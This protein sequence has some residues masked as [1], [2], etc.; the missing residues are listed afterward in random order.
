MANANPARLGQIN[1]AGD[2][3]ALFLPS[4]GGVIVPVSL[5]SLDSRIV[6]LGDSITAAR[7]FA[8][9]TDWALYKARGRYYTKL[10]GS[11]G[12][13]PT[14]WN[15]GVVGNTSAQGIARLSNVS[16]ETPKVVVILFGCNDI[17]NSGGTY[18]SI[19]ANL[20]TIIDAVKA[21]GA[22]CVLCTII[23]GS[24]S[25]YMAAMETIRLNVNDWIRAQTDVTV[26]DTS[27]LI[28]D[29]STQ[30]MVDG[31]HP[32]GT[33]AQLMGYATG[34]VGDKIAS[35]ISASDILYTTGSIPAE[36][37]YTNPLFTGGT[38]SAT[39]WTF[40]SNSNGLTKAASKTTLD[41]YEAQRYVASGTASANSADNF[42][43]NVTVTGGV[44]GDSVEAWVEVLVTK[45]VGISGISISAGTNATAN[46]M[47]S[48]SA[49]DS[50]TRS[51]PF[52]GVM[53]AP[54]SVLTSN[55]QVMNSRISI[56]PANG[57]VVDADITFLRAGYRKV[58]A[59][60]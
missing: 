55:G 17:T 49:Q 37:L 14:G 5:L 28:T 35:L 60:I 11:N 34:G 19:T 42:N 4:H 24:A 41:G 12:T 56:L 6:F 39:G 18:A 25:V 23:P 15:Q 26:C 59:S 53:R 58:P 29:V 2:V 21:M 33:G 22:Q 45:A 51:V 52:R 9:F 10:T 43:Q 50:A 57:A 30:L 27:A 47:M 1:G 54:A 16:A 40:F 44:I 13:G 48:I 7:G 32:N 31:K 38:T 36:N 46:S 3:D 20:R 8:G